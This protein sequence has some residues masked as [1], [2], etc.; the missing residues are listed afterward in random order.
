MTAEVVGDDDVAWLERGAQERSHIGEKQR[1]VHWPV[2][3]HGRSQSVV[4]Q[5][6][7]KGRC[8]PVSMRNRGDAA[9]AGLSSPIASRHV[10]CDPRLIE[11]HQLL[12][13]ERGLILFPS[14]PRLLHVCPFLLAGVQ[15]FFYNSIPIC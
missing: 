11:K 4:S 12:D 5:S 9:L 2:G 14:A 13:V 8:F 10:C 6:S 15:S 7:D 1:A 3:D